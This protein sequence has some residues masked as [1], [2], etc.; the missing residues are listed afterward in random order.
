LASAPV[1]QA[2]AVEAWPLI[3]VHRFDTTVT[4]SRN[5]SSGLRIGLNS[6]FS[7]SVAGRQALGRLA[8]PDEH[9]AESGDGIRRRS[10]TWP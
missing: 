2:A 5:G 8:E 6:K 10:F 7:P 9:R 3:G 4:W 1:D